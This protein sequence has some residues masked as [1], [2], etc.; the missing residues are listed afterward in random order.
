M[1]ETPK[2]AFVSKPD[3]DTTTPKPASSLFAHSQTTEEQKEAPKSPFAGL[4]SAASASSSPFAQGKQV[5]S[6]SASSAPIP[7]KPQQTPNPSFNFSPSDTQTTSTA[8]AEAGSTSIFAGGTLLKPSASNASSDSP[9]QSSANLSA[10]ATQTGTVAPAGSPKPPA[11]YQSTKSV[12]PQKES[13]ASSIHLAP[14]GEP[15]AL[16]ASPAKTSSVVTTS[17]PP[18]DFLGDFTRW[19]LLGD[20]GLFEEFKAYVIE[21]LLGDLYDNFHREQ[22]EQLRKEQ[23]ERLV[24]EADAFRQYNLALRY[25]YRWKTAAR[26]KRLRTIRLEAREEARVFY[27]KQRAAEK[28]ARRQAA[29]RAARAEAEA[30]GL[31]RPEELMSLLKNKR[32]GRREAERALLD[33]GVLSGVGNEQA[34]VAEIVRR[35]ISPS[36]DGSIDGRRSRSGSVASSVNRGGSKTRALR[37]E[38]LGGG[39]AGFRRS[40]PPMSASARSSAEPESSSRKSRVSER[41]RLKAMGITQM[42]DGTAL[43]E[44]LANEILYGKKQHDDDYHFGT[45]RGRSSRRS[46][47]SNSSKLHD[48][49]AMPPPRSTPAMREP[50]DAGS[51]SKRKRSEEDEES[52]QEPRASAHKRIMSGAEQVISEL[53]ALRMEMEEGSAWFREQNERLQGDTRSRGTTP[54]DES[55]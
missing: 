26:E 52:V 51:P 41:W 16:E 4:G 38:L 35:E 19:Y 46:S 28:Q 14:A 18:S 42:P 6:Q 5:S 32:V 24:A 27:E 20:G 44:N 45:A 40:L 53:R 29:A 36:V 50:I 11:T 34:A 13:S 31:N 10:T 2:F 54:W 33:S 1:S 12:A 47:L 30:A 37:N 7:T 39:S 22:E 17:T 55:I 21:N 25:F 48:S 15:N 43:P 49:L 23:E 9:R 3:I 8:T